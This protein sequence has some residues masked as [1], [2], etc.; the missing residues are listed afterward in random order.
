MIHATLKTL[1][2][3]KPKDTYLCISLGMYDDHPSLD[4]SVKEKTYKR[5]VPYNA[6]KIPERTLVFIDF[7][8]F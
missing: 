8:I 6:M 5:M 3:A 4:W 1:K 2:I 7:F